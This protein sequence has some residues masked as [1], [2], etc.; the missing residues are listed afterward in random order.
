MD[1]KLTPTESL[2]FANP[3]AAKREQPYALTSL[4][5]LVIGRLENVSELLI[6]IRCQPPLPLVV[7][8]AGHTKRWV[9]SN[10]A[11]VLRVNQDA[12]E[13]SS[14]TR[15]GAGSAGYDNFSALVWG[16]LGSGRF[17]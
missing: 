11:A 3:S 10:N 14:R 7:G 1:L 4:R 6:F 5:D 13:Q 17:T 2:D 12:V 15:G 9:R 8:R 16:R